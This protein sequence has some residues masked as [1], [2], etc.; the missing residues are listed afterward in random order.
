MSN[1]DK[2][3]L[4]LYSDSIYE[5]PSVTVDAVIF[6]IKTKKSEN[7]RKLAQKKLQVFLSKR[8]YPPFKDYFGVIGTFIDLNYE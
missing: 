3:F 2:E 5:K 8:T 4:S 6:R 7:Y 1:N